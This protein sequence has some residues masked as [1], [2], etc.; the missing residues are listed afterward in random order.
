[1]IEKWLEGVSQQRKCFGEA[2]K[3]N[4]TMGMTA[5]DAELKG[6]INRH[7]NRR[8]WMGNGWENAK[9]SAG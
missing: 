9:T 4:E 1:M 8:I 6:D 3:A 2:K 7:L 5:L